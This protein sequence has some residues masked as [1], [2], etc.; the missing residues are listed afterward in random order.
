MNYYKRH[1]GDY[2]KDTGHMSAL[3]HGVY[4][5][6]LDR[7]YSTEKP[8]PE[9]DALR[10]ARAKTKEERSAV[11]SVLA[12]FFKFDAESKSYRHSYAD[13]VI[14]AAHEKAEANRENGRHGGRPAKPRGNPE[15]T[16]MVPD[17]LP[18]KTLATNPL[19]T[20]HKPLANTQTDADFH[21]FWFAYP[22][23]KGRAKAMEAYAKA[24]TKAD[25]ATLMAA[26]EAQKLWP[27][28]LRENGR[29]IP[30]AT[31][32]LNQSR[33]EDEGRDPAQQTRNV[34]EEAERIAFGSA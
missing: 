27:E 30:H 24:L 28:W 31:T 16:Q 19:A 18:E 33:W 13:R 5:L 12:E 3:E 15:E 4:T 10:V 8:I 29:F 26:L 11:C 32:W 1:L 22:L 9:A 6:L 25:H 34:I 2:A 21:A 20:S 14:R 7:Y 17:G 23:K